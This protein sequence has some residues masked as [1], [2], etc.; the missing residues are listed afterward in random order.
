MTTRKC[1]SPT[2]PPTGKS[3]SFLM[4]ASPVPAGCARAPTPTDNPKN[5]TE[6]NLAILD[7]ATPKRRNVLD[8][9][10]EI[11]KEDASPGYLLNSFG[12]RLSLKPH[13]RWPKGGLAVTP[14][15]TN[16]WH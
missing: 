8:V 9:A 11:N 5:S 2:P 10:N 3:F 6:K 12:L 13:R 15:G 1:V 14:L 4:S 16:C 7:M